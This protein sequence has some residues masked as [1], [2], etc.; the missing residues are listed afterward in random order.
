M[1]GMFDLFSVA[2]L[3]E[4]LTSTS[5]IIVLNFLAFIRDV[6]DYVN[7]YVNGYVRILLYLDNDKAGDKATRYLTEKFPSVIDQRETYKN[8]KDLNEHLCH[9]GGS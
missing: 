6:E 1:E 4:E 7:H 5:D 2:V 8:H 3:E 9:V